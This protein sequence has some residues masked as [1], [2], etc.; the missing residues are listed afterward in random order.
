[1]APIHHHVKNLVW[2]AVAVLRNRVRDL[3]EQ[4][5]TAVHRRADAYV[6]GPE[7]ASLIELLGNVEH[8][9]GAAGRGEQDRVELVTAFCHEFVRAVRVDTPEMREFATELWAGVEK[10]VPSAVR[11][12][13]SS[14]K[15]LIT[16]T[17]LERPVAERLALAVDDARRR[18]AFDIGA[19]I[20]EAMAAAHTRMVM[21]HSKIDYRFAMAQIYV[22]RTIQ[23]KVEHGE[24]TLLHET[25]LTAH[26]FVV[27]GNP[28]AGKS[29]FIR[30]L[31]HRVA[32]A[33]DGHLVPMVVLLKRH[34]SMQDDFAT[35]IA[36]ELR[37]LVQRDVSRREI[38]DLFN[39]GAGL[40]VFDGLDEVGDVQGR[41]AAVA[42]IEAFAMRYPL[43]RIVVT[44]REESYP[45]AQLDARAFPVYLLPD[46]DEKQVEQYVSTWFG[47][48]PHHLLGPEAR[49]SAF[50]RDSGHVP[51][52]R[53][54]PLM[55]SLLC[56]LYQNEGYIPENTADVYQEC[57]ELMLV[58]WDAVSHV[59]SVIKS[60]VKLAKILVQELAQ[61]FFFE[62]GGEEAAS[63]KALRRLV[64]AHLEARED[65]DTR[66]YHQQA[67]DF[68]EYCAER[69]WVLTQVDTTADGERMFGFTHRTFME[70]YTARHVL[71]TRETAE[72]LT[73]CLLPM[74]TSGKSHVVPQ[75]ALQI[76]DQNRADGG[77][78]CV[79]LLLEAAR[80]D[81]A[82]FERLSL[83]TFCVNFLEHNH[84]QHAT[85]DAVLEYAFAVLGETGD[86]VLRAALIAL[87]SKRKARAATVARAVIARTADRR[88]EFVDIRLGAGLVV[89]EPAV[90]Y[91][92]A[93]GE[94][95]HGMV[96]LDSFVRRHRR[97]TLLYALL[98][99]DGTEYVPGPLIRTKSSEQRAKL[100]GLLETA[101][102]DVLPIPVSVMPRLITDETSKVL[103]TGSAVG[104]VSLLAAA[105][106][107]ADV[108]WGLSGELFRDHIGSRQEF[109]E[110][111]LV[112]CLH[113]DD[114]G[115]FRGCLRRWANGE[116]SFVDFER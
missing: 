106:F 75:V 50:L 44:C 71:R 64:V 11:R 72:Q 15:I 86:R 41:R 54:N 105:A 42:A 116:M 28:G 19:A 65:E 81:L 33:D 40:V 53:S 94:V 111:L 82:A 60:S 103:A 46:F 66:T 5:P 95:R 58:R 93:L 76:Y 20:R 77:D 102:T 31:V 32:S 87:R 92:V 36:N 110:R 99:G 57:A 115:P 109:G 55:L 16:A 68:L 70:Y 56:M 61:Y 63:E 78:T 91:E 100:V 29:T 14:D 45:V 3:R 43:A 18:E 38:A 96:D 48:V 59:P 67:Q 7:C 74:I 35:I 52:L 89:R 98:P 47:L 113:L 2:P 34:Q 83:I 112:L 6:T 51:D 9:S 97:R 39:S 25:E 10:L 101:L 30:N 90:A 79:R 80:G 73:D 88:D 37:P 4:M 1:M 24:S 23:Q 104:L 8:T 84:V 22:R 17:G 13:P 108:R 12:V 69:A 114:L 21:P 107:E 27:V 85:V 62:L 26:R 49:A